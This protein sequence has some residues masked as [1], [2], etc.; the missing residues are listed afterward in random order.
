MVSRVRS[1]INKPKL[2]AGLCLV[3][4]AAIIA[5]LLAMPP[6]SPSS[7]RPVRLAPVKTATATNLS[8]L[9][10]NAS[11]SQSSGQS[12]PG[13]GNTALGA[14]SMGSMGNSSS[15][16]NPSPAASQPTQ[17]E[18]AAPLYP[19]DPVK[20]HP[21]TNSTGMNSYACPLCGGSTMCAIPW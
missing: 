14:S 9:D 21:P 12:M 19:V 7:Y 2:L 6:I 13:S 1:Y 15:P 18:T 8:A 20:C 11:S 5:V 4:I 10:F 3:G 16:T 17:I